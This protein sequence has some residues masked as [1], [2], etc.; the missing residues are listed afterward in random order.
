MRRTDWMER[1]EAGEVPHAI[2]FAGP[3]ESGALMLARCAAARYL[4]HT[5]DTNALSGCPFYQEPA[6]FQVKTLRDA[7]AV[8]NAEAYGKGRRCILFPN[9]HTMSEAAQD[10]LLKTLEEPPEDTLLLL[11]GVESGFRPT[12][13]SR[14]MI[15]RSET[16]PW[17]TI[18]K[19]LAENGV[20]REQAALAAKLSDGVYGRAEAFLQEDALAFRR[21]AIA[22]IGTFATRVKP[23]AELSALCTET[24]TEQSEDGT[25]KKTKKVST[26]AVDRVLD[27]FLSILSDVLRQKFGISEMRNTDCTTVEKNFNSTFT[28]A[29]IQGMIQVAAEAKEMLSY[30]ANPAMVVD[31]ILAKLP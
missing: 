30:K 17:E 10:V 13:L 20:R 8:I 4:L 7:L 5:D 18:A 21:E 31:W 11:T 16:E 22:C 1:I 26:A 29:Q 6:D 2:L 27:L 24:V 25:V 3:Q 19:R 23:Y 28:T 14:C 15:L 9:A 12:V